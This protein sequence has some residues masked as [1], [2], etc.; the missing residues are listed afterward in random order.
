MFRKSGKSTYKHVPHREKPVHL[1]ARRNA[2]ERRRVQ[3]VNSAF[4]RLR[5]CVP[6]ENRNKRLSKVKTLQRAIEYIAALQDVLQDAEEQEDGL[7]MT[8]RSS[9]ASLN[10]PDCESGD[11]NL[12]AAG[13]C[14]KENQ[15][16][17]HR[18]VADQRWISLDTVSCKLVGALVN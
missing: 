1:V 3:A 17:L 2:R 16:H 11:H 4:A 9:S 13:K 8:G 5:K 10:N 7:M 18:T 12:N 14:D 6:V 15:H